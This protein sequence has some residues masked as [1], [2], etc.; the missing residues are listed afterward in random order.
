MNILGII[1]LGQNPAA[2]LLQDGKLVAFV[3]EERFTRLK[4]SDKMFPSF[5]AAY[6][7]TSVGLTLNDV[8]R[9]AFGWD[10]TQYPWGVGR[11]FCLNYLRYGRSARTANSKPADRSAVG[12]AFETLLEFHPTRVRARITQGLRSVGLKGDIPPIVFVPHHLAHAYSAY[13]C[14]GFDKAGILVIDGSGEFTCTQLAI[15]EGQS[16]RVVDSIPIPHSLGWFYAAITEYLGFTP[17]RDEGKLMGL[18]ALGEVRREENRWV[19]TMDGI[20]KVG[21]AGYEVSP[22]YT[23]FGGHYYGSRFTDELVQLL[24]SVDRSALP[25]GRGEKA[26]I[27]G[28]P[29]SRYLLDT[30]VDLA[31][32]AQKQLERAT[33][34][35]A[36]RLISEDQKNI[37]IA[38]GVGLNCKMNGEVLRQSGCENIFVQPAASD[39]GTALG[40]AL[41]VAGQ[42]GERI[43]NSPVNVYLGPGYSNDE[44]RGVLENCKLSYRLLSD[45][46]DEAAVLLEQ[47]QIVAWFQDRM[48]FGARAL[49]NRSI[50]ANPTIP[51]AKEKVNREVK[52]RESWRPFC[53]SIAAESLSDYVAR[54]NEASF[55]IVAYEMKKTAQQQL[56]SVVHVDGTIRP[57]AVSM[58][59][60]PL[61]ASL[62]ANM[63]KRCGH[64]VVLNTSL[65]VRGEPIVCSPSEAVRCFHGTGLDALIMGDLIVQKTS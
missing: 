13:F 2:C 55:M 31:W 44:I 25:V 22:I 64:P 10:A 17:Y 1:G 43:D 49:G 32:A 23:K 29:Q 28:E 53:P 19:D 61:F 57:Q 65:N 4:G 12:S 58:H 45:P 26:K 46:A 40:A 9:I 41:Y 37:C 60:N 63:G 8:D 34:M 39:A 38:G 16:I 20:L 52:Y 42:E 59:A 3:E 50:L 51:S 35:L 54:P 62:L 27:G 21:H 6:C 18:A 24:T 7:L 30:Y 56:S 47:G 15:G 36:R 14:S 48:E 33:V 5:A 11:N